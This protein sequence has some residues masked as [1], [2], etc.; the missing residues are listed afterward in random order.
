MPEEQQRMWWQLS[1]GAVTLEF[2]QELEQYPELQGF[3]AITE[4]IA[5]YFSDWPWHIEAR[6]QRLAMFLVLMKKTN[7]F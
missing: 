6:R 1:Y 3:E 7:N 4:Y 2:L 5:E